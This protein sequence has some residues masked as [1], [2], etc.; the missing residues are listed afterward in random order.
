MDETE[1]WSR[2]EFR[3]CREMESI[4]ECGRQGLWCDGFIPEHYGLDGSPASITGRVWIGFGA[5]IQEKWQFRLIL[6]SSPGSPRKIQWAE[7][8]PAAELTGW[9]AVNTQDKRIELEPARGR[10]IT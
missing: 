4:E 7:L 8:L 9:L 3:V 10:S 6:G 1:F 2:L 5:R